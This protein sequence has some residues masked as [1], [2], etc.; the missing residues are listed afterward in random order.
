MTSGLLISRRKKYELSKSFTKNRTT[1]NAAKFKTYRNLY[2]RVI[3]NAKKLYFEKQLNLY[4]S[5]LRKTWSIIKMA[6]KAPTKKQ[7]GIND[8]LLN[9]ILTYNSKLIAD[10]LNSFFVNMPS[11]IV[12]EIPDCDV[13][14]DQFFVNNPDAPTFDF[15]NNPVTVS[16][17]LEA[18]KELQP[19]KSEDMFGLSMFFVKQFTHL[20]IKPLHHIIATSFEKGTFPSQ[21]KI[22]KVIPLH[23]GG[24]STV[25]DNYRPISL[26]PNISKIYEKIASIRLTH[27]LETNNLLSNRQFGFRKNHSTLHPLTHFVNNI[28]EALNK[29]KHCISIFCDLRKAFDTVDHDILIKK[30]FQIGVRGTAHSWFRSY[31]SNRKQF[32]HVNNVQSLLLDII[33]GVPQGSILGPLLF[34]IY[35]NDLPL[36]SKL[37]SL[38]FADDTTLQASSS[39]LI[40]LTQFVNEEFKKVVNFFRAHKLA[41]HLSKTSFMI[42]SNSRNINFDEFKVYIDFNN[43]NLKCQDK[44][45]QM[46]CINTLHEPIV[47]FLGLYIDSSLSF[48]YHINQLSKKIST[49]LY[50]LRS[51]RNILT[52]KA[53][54][55][56]YYALIHSHLIYGIQIWSCTSPS[57]VKQLFIKQKNAIRVISNSSYNAH[58]EPLFKKLKILPLPSL[59]DFFKLQFMQQFSQGFL[60]SSFNETWTSNAIRNEGTDHIVLRSNENFII[61]FARLNTTMLHPL[62]S[63]PK[64]WE[65]FPEGRIKFIRNKSEFNSELKKYY[66]NNLSETPN[67]DRLFC[68]SCNTSGINV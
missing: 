13:K 17:I 5:N 24:D 53:L 30:L 56:L 55:S 60:P 35:V 12:S 18:I 1:E 40:D 46:K 38:L 22:A 41:L 9:G 6:I 63:F 8:L 54:K 25:P 49:S 3:R 45:F 65:N 62:T 37:I 7:T 32:V 28:S 67:C 44:I 21:L 23:K 26:L 36:W 4:Q 10:T 2:Y 51:A 39:N 29:K 47:K 27:F 61:P 14:F 11:K 43:S 50:F 64:I 68:P 19:K 59:I 16:E 66:L 42:F 58:T 52:E 57:I 31:L 34:L 33:L 15:Q 48:K 20:I